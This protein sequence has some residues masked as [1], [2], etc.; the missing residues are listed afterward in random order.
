MQVKPD[1]Q[2]VI[3]SIPICHYEGKLHFMIYFSSCMV[4]CAM[5]MNI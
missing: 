1:K 3:V 4:I 5:V 2:P